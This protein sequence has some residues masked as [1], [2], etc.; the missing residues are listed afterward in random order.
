MGKGLAQALLISSMEAFKGSAGV[1]KVTTPGMLQYCLDNNKPDVISVGKDDGTGYI[2]DVKL[3]YRNRGITGI[4]TTNDDCS[5]QA[6]PAY[7][8]TTVASTAHRSLGMAFEDDVI[9]KFEQ[10][11][12]AAV[13]AGTPVMTGLM[14]DVYEAIIEQANGLFGDINNDLLA[15]QAANWGVNVTTGANTAKTVNFAL[16]TATNPLNAGMTSVMADAMSNEMRMADMI[17]VGS[18]LINNYYLQQVAKSTDQAGVNTA[19]LALPKFYFDPY[20]TSAWGANKFGLFEK[21]AVQFVNLCR[22]RGIKAGQKGSDYFMTLR[23]P[24][25]D[26]L[27]QGNLSAFEFDVQIKYRTCPGD[28]QIGTAGQGNP[29]VSLGRGWNIII[30]SSYQLVHQPSNTYNAADRLYGVNGTLLYNATNA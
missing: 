27:G 3:R 28:V 23:L 22:F 7:L 15:V 13:N 9:A 11:A 20:A 18:G 6:R 12:L 4:S 29:P 19:G 16:S 10:D 5:I 21:N 17:I 26:S 2:R 30:S 14:K 1:S 8:E 24:I 25:V